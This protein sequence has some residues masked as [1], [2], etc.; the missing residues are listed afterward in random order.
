MSPKTI[1]LRWYMW[2]RALRIDC[3]NAHL[4]GFSIES[5]ICLHG[6]AKYYHV[7]LLDC[8]LGK[9][10]QWGTDVAISTMFYCLVSVSA[11]LISM[12]RVSNNWRWCHT[13]ERM[14]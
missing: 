3:W 7:Y 14:F 11:Q 2:S 10:E 6:Y 9:Q 1:L 5:G 12:G 13:V 8:D 4:L